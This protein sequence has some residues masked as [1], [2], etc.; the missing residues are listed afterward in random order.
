MKVMSQDV[1]TQQELVIFLAKFH[2][3]ALSTV[4]VSESNLGKRIYIW[5]I[6]RV[7]HIDP[8]RL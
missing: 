3:I 4:L 2:Q 8:N 7:P 1:A 5:E 6:N